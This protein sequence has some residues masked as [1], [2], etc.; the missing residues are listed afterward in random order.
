MEEEKTFTIEDLVEFKKISLSVADKKITFENTESAY[1]YEDFGWDH[2]P[3]Y[4]YY[5]K[6]DIHI[7][8]DLI[9][10]DPILDYFLIDGNVTIDGTFSLFNMDGV[11]PIAIMGNLSAKNL[12]IG[13]E[14]MLYILGNATIE[15]LLLSSLSDAGEFILHKN[16]HAKHTAWQY[17]E[18]ITF[19]DE[20]N[21]NI[22]SEIVEDEELLKEEFI[23]EPENIIAAINNGINIYLD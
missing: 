5:Y 8:G 14:S 15:E 18:N 19:V 17:N 16:V 6:G 13:N 4:L 20:D 22:P 12:I 7:K 11:N 3:D 10:N 9:I 21:F 23:D 1:E 2:E